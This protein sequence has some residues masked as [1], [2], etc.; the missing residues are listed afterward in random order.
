[1]ETSENTLLGGRVN[2]TQPTSGF[3]S[4]IDAV[5]LASS[6]NAKPGSRILDAGCGVGA[7]TLCLLERCPKVHVTGIDVQ[8]DYIDLAKQNAHKN[9]RMEATTFVT[10]SLA[11]KS[12]NIFPNSFD[13]VMSNPPYFS[14]THHTAPNAEDRSIAHV[15]EDITLEAWL[16][17]CIKMLKPRGLLHLVYRVDRLDEMISI[18][19]PKAGGI[20]V[21][22]LWPKQGRDAKLVLVSACKG[23]KAPFTLRPGLVVHREQGGY[24]SQAENILR[25][26]S[27]LLGLKVI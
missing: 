20:T 3:R 5:F 15:G 27:S 25:Q 6:V 8:S 4:G 21:I 18:L 9:A 13:H 24:T 12:P 7:V 2:L 14:K 23:S 22:P 11:E 16:T 17:Y 10:G 1:M 19:T 26:G